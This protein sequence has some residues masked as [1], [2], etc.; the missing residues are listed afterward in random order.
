[1][2]TKY[3]FPGST[4]RWANALWLLGISLWL[5]QWLQCV[6]EYCFTSLSAQSCLCRDGR[7]SEVVPMPYSYR[8][9]SRVLCGARYLSQHCIFQSFEQFEALHMH[10]DEFRSHPANTRHWT[11]VI[12]MLAHQLWRWPSIRITL[13]QCVVFAR[14]EL[15][16]KSG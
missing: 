4:R 7:K 10:R 12:L 6:S 16:K 11:N 8:M 1:M 2:L 9:T 3:T 15:Q 14:H 13:G 5:T